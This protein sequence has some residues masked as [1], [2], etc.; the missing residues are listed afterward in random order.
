MSDK[1]KTKEQP[2]ITLT[3]KL[4]KA[5][6]QA[7]AKVNAKGKKDKHKKKGNPI[8]RYFKEMRSELKKVVWPSRKKVF[9]NTGVVMVVM[10]IV[11]IVLF[12]VD[13][14]LSAL[15]QLAFGK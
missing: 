9:H 14:G 8:V 5:K 11:A 6:K 10:V 1:N 12:G 15:V 7:E 2:K 3:T 4:E 13:T